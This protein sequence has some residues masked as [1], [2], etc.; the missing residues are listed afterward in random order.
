MM[1]VTLLLLCS[2]LAV[3]PEFLQF[4]S[5][6]PVA[7]VPFSLPFSTLPLLPFSLQDCMWHEFTRPWLGLRDFMDGQFTPIPSLT[8]EEPPHL[9]I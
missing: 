5:T 4:S 2:E 3:F 8:L 6:I 1:K 7:R 9:P